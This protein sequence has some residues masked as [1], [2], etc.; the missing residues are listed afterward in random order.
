MLSRLKNYLGRFTGTEQKL[1]LIF[2]V[3]LLGG[4]VLASWQSGRGR[5]AVPAQGGEYSEGLAGAPQHINPLLAPT[6]DVDQDLAR[7]VYAGLYKFDPD[8]NLTPD[9][10]ESQPQVAGGGKEYTITLREN[11]YWQDGHKLTADDAVYTFQ[12]IQNPNYQI[13]NSVRL[14]WN[15]VGVEKIDERRLKLTTREASGTF[16]AN[17]TVGLLPKHIWETVAAESFGLSKLNLEPVGSG[18]FQVTEARRNRDGQIREIRLKPFARYHG[19]APYLKSLV[20]KFYPT[21]D[22][23]ISAYQKNE[24]MGLGYVPYDQSLFLR[25]RGMNQFE[26]PLPQYQAVFINRAKNP[27]PLEDARVR[28]ALAKSVDKQQIIRDVFGGHASE[29]YG[30][31][32]PGMLGYH[33]EIPGAPMNLHDEAAAKALLD[34]AGWIMDSATGFRRDKLG[35]IITLEL[36]TNNFSPNVRVAEILKK[37]WEGIGIQIILRIETTADLENKFIRPRQYEL[38]LYSENTGPDPDPYPYWHSSQLRNPGVNLSTFRSAATDK[39]LLEARGIISAE[40]RAKKY[41]RFQELF[42]GDVPA[43]F[44]TRSVYVYNVSTAVKGLTLKTVVLPAERFA[45][46]SKWYIATKRVKQVK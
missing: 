18:P 8:L 4:I 1:L 44:L 34:E 2:F 42:V 10:A 7:V 33:E 28:L 11:L 19:G 12:T 43:V 22:G 13:P 17:L 32:L 20:F 6:N 40:E 31:I 41:R 36:A 15:Q 46:I 14:S 45:D 23:L 9:L 35:R 16:I 27:A 37:T 39:L 30:P 5:V 21:T 29:A 25:P 3:L 38:L 26:L 24:I